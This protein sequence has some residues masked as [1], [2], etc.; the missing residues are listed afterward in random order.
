MQV[1]P[2]FIEDRQVQEDIKNILTGD[3]GIPYYYVNYTGYGDDNSD[4]YFVHF[5]YENY[6]HSHDCSSMFDR[7]LS[8][9]IGRLKFNYLMRAKVNLYT[10]KSEFIQKAEAILVEGFQKFKLSVE[11]NVKIYFYP[12]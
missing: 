6:T 5:L 9:I 10:I 8:P 11:D 4:F 1:I 2:N 7:I 3:R 12:R